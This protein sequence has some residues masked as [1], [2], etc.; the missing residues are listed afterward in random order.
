MFIFLFCS[1]GRLFKRA[2]NQDRAVKRVNTVTNLVNLL[3]R[4][5][6]F[7]IETFRI[8][9]TVSSEE[10]FYELFCADHNCVLSLLLRNINNKNISKLLFLLQFTY[11]ICLKGDNLERKHKQVLKT[12]S[13]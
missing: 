3:L 12:Q 11:F 13:G 10:F 9:T 6:R 7:R 8:L 2:L 5:Y 4:L 1:H